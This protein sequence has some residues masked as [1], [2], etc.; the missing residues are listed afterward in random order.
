MVVWVTGALLVGMMS[1]PRGGFVDVIENSSAT[2]AK[3]RFGGVQDEP[4]PR[5]RYE[6]SLPASDAVLSAHWETA[7]G[8]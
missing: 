5:K 2:P 3:S 6:P 8:R 4:L 1:V 7:A